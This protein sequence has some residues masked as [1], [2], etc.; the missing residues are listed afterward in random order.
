MDWCQYDEVIPDK[1]D[2]K[3]S[4][5]YKKEVSSNDSENFLHA[6]ISK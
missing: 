2:I 5:N 1:E 4:K 3:A 6:L